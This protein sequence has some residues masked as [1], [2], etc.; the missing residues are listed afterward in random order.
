MN[1]LILQCCVFF[2]F[3]SVYLRE[4]VSIMLQFPTLGV[5]S[6][7]KMNLVDALGRSFFEFPRK[8]GIFRQNQ[9]STKLISLYGCNSKTNHC[10]YLKFSTNVH[11][12]IIYIQ[13]NFQKILTFLIQIFCYKYKFAF[14][15]PI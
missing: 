4:K 2:F 10:K 8:T 13:L 11:V 6:D 7:S 9:F 5:V 14:S 15:L 1:V 12:S 3:V